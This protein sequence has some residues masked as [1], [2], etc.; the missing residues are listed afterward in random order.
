MTFELKSLEFR[1][2]RETAWRELEELLARVDRKGLGGLSADQLYRLPTLYRGVVSSLSVA[3][4]ISLD[5][6]LQEYLENLAAR[7][8]VYVYGAKRGYWRAVVDFFAR[9]FPGLVWALRRQ[10]AVSVL[11]LVLG[12]LTG[13]HLTGTDP[14]RY[15]AFMPEEMAAGREPS[16]SR[17]ELLEVLRGG[18]PEE[19]AGVSGLTWF[20]GQLFTHNARIGM[21]CFALGFAAGVPVALL[22]FGNG[23]LLGAFAAIHHRQDLA[24]EMWGWLLPHGV[25]E[26]LA[27]C[28]CGA[29]GLAVGQA[30]A[31][32]GRARRMDAL[33][34]AGRRAAAVVLGTL[35][36]FFLA[37]LIEGY[38]RQLVLGDLPRYALAT[39]T[40]VLWV[41]YFGVLGRRV[42]GQARVLAGR[43]EVRDVDGPAAADPRAGLVATGLPAFLRGRDSAA[44]AAAVERLSAEGTG[45]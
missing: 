32:P 31:F 40:A 34:A 7:A 33:A 24:F 39:A 19:R 21:L 23:V 6:A 28:L 11:L 36:M 14:D 22:L 45:P 17:E 16:S 29:A 37:G 15:F 20:A 42:V 27:V 18:P 38:F 4:S 13:Y 2:E 1:R 25:T 43:Q 35:V 5:R 41:G 8:Y 12:V 26:L 44:E 30:V 3:R 9:R 10:V